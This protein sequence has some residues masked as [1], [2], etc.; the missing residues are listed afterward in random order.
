M[1]FFFTQLPFTT[2]LIKECISQVAWIVMHDGRKRYFI[3]FLLT[4][5]P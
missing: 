3:Y 2:H 5:F 4:T 1:Y